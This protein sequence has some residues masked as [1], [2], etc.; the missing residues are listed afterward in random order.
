MMLTGIMAASGILQMLVTGYKIN[1]V[2]ML[3]IERND[4]DLAI[5]SGF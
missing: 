3:R 1:N 4:V 2:M 5:G